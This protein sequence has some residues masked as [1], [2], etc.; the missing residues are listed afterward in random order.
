MRLIV[1]GAGGHA[2]VVIDV[3]RLAFPDCE[4][5]GLVDD[6]IP[7]GARVSGL[8]VLG[9]IAALARVPHDAVV[10]AVGD[11]TARARIFEGLRAAGETLPLLV[12]P[13]AAVASSAS[14]GS[15]TLV[16]AH[17]V[18]N[19]EAMVDE[20]VIVN[21]AATIDHHSKIG[22]HA[23]IA[24]GVHLAGGCRVGEGGA[25]GIG[26]IIAPAVSIGARTFVGAGSVVL[27]DLPADVIAY[28]SP[29]RVIRPRTTSD[30][31]H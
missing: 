29:A 16:L 4:L 19:A 3:A 28:G 7:V 23:H 10:L 1:A 14:L 5:V 20:N 12:H 9:P 24:P 6:S 11:N 17:A 13:S 26:T 30:T 31:F 21:T 25:I 2:S 8:S 22:R 15:G 27:E 18:I